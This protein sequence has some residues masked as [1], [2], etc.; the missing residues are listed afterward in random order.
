[1]N[2]SLHLPGRIVSL[3]RQLVLKG[4]LP[5][6]VV[7]LAMT[8]TLAVMQFRALGSEAHAVAR[9]QAVRLAG[10][11][12]GVMGDDALRDALT[13]ALSRSAPTQRAI[14]YRDD[15]P[16]LIVTS[17][18]DAPHRHGLH[19]RLST[20]AGQLETVSDASALRE[21][22]TAATLMCLLLGAGVCGVFFLAR[23][24]VEH[25][26]AQPVDR[27]R[28]RLVQALH[29]RGTHA[30]TPDDPVRAIDTL[31]DEL[32]QLRARHEAAMADALRQRLQDIARHTRFVE[33]IGDHFRQPLQALSLFVAGMQPG[34]DLRQRAVLGQMRTSLTRLTEL[35]DGLLEMARFDAGAVEPAPTA[36]L[37]ADLFVRVRSHVEADAMRLGVDVR[38]RGG[39]V[40]FHADGAL[41]V[42]LLNR[43]VSCAVLS[44]PHGRVLV[45]IRRRGDAIRLEVRD[46]GMGVEPAEQARLFEEFTRLPGQP[47]Y[48]LA[49]AV[50]RRIADTLGGH[51][52]VRSS[53]GR[54]TLF[55][56]ELDHAAIGPASRGVVSALIRH[57]AS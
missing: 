50:A 15:A 32:V 54:G 39:R 23:R 13:R 35:L 24:A 21:R 36:V 48:G 47:G 10:S 25:D 14:L 16:D 4:L 5:M 9:I 18:R 27:L 22:R 46:N 38:W 42:E 8:A 20:A 44:T 52:G 2:A 34:E 45:A 30:G 28:A 19:V 31:L 29:P 17:G 56:V 40:P 1:M 3:R 33:Q 41:L 37:A 49:L 57:A 55:W 51:I 53:P 11:V 6:T 43:L 26:V 7:A 12:N